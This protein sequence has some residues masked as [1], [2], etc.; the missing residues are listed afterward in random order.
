MEEYSSYLQS[1]KVIIINID[2]N[3]NISDNRAVGGAVIHTTKDMSNNE[4]SK[5]TDVKNLTISISNSN[6]SNNEA[7]MDGGVYL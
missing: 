6:F 4:A 2:N 3:T 5:N 1:V 7:S